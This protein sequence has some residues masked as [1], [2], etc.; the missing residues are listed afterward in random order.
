MPTYEVDNCTLGFNGKDY[1]PGKPVEM[2]E[3]QA[4]PLLDLGVLKK[5]VA[6]KEE[7]PVTQEEIIEAIKS[8]DPDDKKLWTKGGSGPPQT[9]AI[10]DVLGKNKNVSAADRDKAMKVINSTGEGN[11]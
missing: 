11:Q 5:G 10:E 3:K 4:T 2:T 9:S 6:K 8:L 1:A 7:N